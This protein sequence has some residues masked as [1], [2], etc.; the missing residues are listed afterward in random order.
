MQNLA[1]LIR[2][3]PANE[4]ARKVPTFC[5]CHFCDITADDCPVRADAGPE[6]GQGTTD[7]F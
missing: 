2:R 5:E 3:L 1:A 6:T 7:D 4:P